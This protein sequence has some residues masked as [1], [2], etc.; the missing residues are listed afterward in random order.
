LDHF[1]D[2]Y[3]LPRTTIKFIY[4]NG[5]YVNPMQTVDQT[6]WAS[7]TT[8]DLEWGHAVAPDAT[9]V[10]IVT[11]SSESTGMNGMQD[12]FKGIQMAIQQYPHAIISM[13]FGTGEATFSSDDTKTYLQGAFHKIL[14]D[15]T[16]AGFSLLSSAGDSGSAEINTDQSS[17]FSFPNA[18][19]PA[20]DPLVTAVGGTAIETGWLWTPEGIADDYW[21]C[22]LANKKSCPKNFLKSVVTDST[23]ES[24]WKEDWAI[25]AGGGGISTVFSAPDYQTS[26]EGNVVSQ[27]SGKRG[28]PD[29]SM[30]AAI[31]GGVAVY[32]SA[33][34]QGSA[35]SST[36]PAWQAFGGTSCASPET[37]GLIAL[38]GQAASDQLGKSVSVGS[39]NQALYALPESDFNDIVPQTFG[40]DNQV[41][42]DND[43]LYFSQN[44]LAALGPTKIPPV[45]VPGYKTTVGYD[46]ATGRGSPRAQSFVQDLARATVLRETAN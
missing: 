4:P 44:V 21:A 24:V 5:T 19:Y 43:G 29:V 14:Q 27:L 30:N 32:M 12:I 41:V 15:A 45:A 46:L 23:V 38:A 6:S 1:S 31:N 22:L 13:S 26:L 9:L 28:I 25:A 42:I 11:S 20:S 36:G 8:L 34:G 16:D 3:G 2:T 17:M 37:A 35:S 33:A 7:E 18:S 10:N 39:L 40:A